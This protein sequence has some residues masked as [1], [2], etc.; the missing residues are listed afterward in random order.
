MKD[1]KVEKPISGKPALKAKPK[2]KPLP[3]Q[4]P[5]K[6]KQPVKVKPIKAK[7]AVP[8]KTRPVSAKGAGKQPVK[9]QMPKIPKHKQLPKQPI[10]PKKACSAKT[11]KSSC[12]DVPKVK[13]PAKKVPAKSPQA[14]GKIPKAKA[15]KAPAKKN[16]PHNPGIP[17][18]KV[19]KVR[20]TVTAPPIKHAAK[21]TPT[22]KPKVCHFM[23]HRISVLMIG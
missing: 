3:K 13:P 16:N 20:Q 19:E 14:K 22:P 2:S 7:Q 17:P 15:K 18:K 5:P 4:V 8:A 6:V 21:I 23:Y 9:K 12:T 11:T 1:A 10:Q